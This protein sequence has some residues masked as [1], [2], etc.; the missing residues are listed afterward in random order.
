MIIAAAIA[1]W[2]AIGFLYVRL[3]HEA[4]GWIIMITDTRNTPRTW[5][6]WPS[7]ILCW[8]LWPISGWVA[9]HCF[10]LSITNLPQEVNEQ[11]IRDSF[12]ILDD[13]IDFSVPPDLYPM[14]INI[15][16]MY[17]DVIKLHVP[18]DKD[19]KDDSE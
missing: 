16:Y 2:I 5:M 7:I 8:V 1:L 10:Y 15:N 14:D 12:L 17:P 9:R 18:I 3:T 19:K 13:T 4:G 6:T 11:R